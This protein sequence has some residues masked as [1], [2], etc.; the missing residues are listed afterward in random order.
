MVI[1]AAA[2]AAL[3]RPSAVRADIT[4]DFSKSDLKLEVNL[5]TGD[6]YMLAN[7]A[8]AFS[9]YTIADPAGFLLGGSTS[10]DPAK[11]LSVSPTAGG[12]TNIY[13]STGNYVNWFKITETASQIAEGQYNNG[14]TNHSSRDDT[15]NIPSGG[16]I[17]FGDIFNTAVDDQD[18]TFDFAEAGTTPTNGR[19]Y[20]GAEVDYLLAGSS[21]DLFW[22]NT[23]ATSNWSNPN[24]WSANSSTGTDNAGVPT[25]G[26]A[27]F[28][29]NTD[30]QN[31]VIT[32]DES[33]AIL[34]LQIGDTGGGTD[35]LSQ[36]A[37]YNL[38]MQ[39]EQVGAASNGTGIHIQS[40]GNNTFSNSLIVG[41][42]LSSNGTYSLSGTGAVNVATASTGTF[43]GMFVGYGGNGTFAQTGGVATIGLPA[44]PQSL[45]LGYAVPAAGTFL[46]SGSGSLVVNGNAYIG[47]DGTGAFLQSGGAASISGNVILAGTD[48]GS[49]GTGTLAISGGSINV[50]G[51][52]TVYPGGT[53]S[54]TAGILT[55]G[56]ITQSGGIASFTNLNVGTANTVAGGNAASYTLNSGTLN[57]AGANINSGAAFI[58]G[59]GSSPATLNLNGGANNALY[60]FAQGITVSS[61]A[62]LTGGGEITN[63]GF[64]VPVTVA[65]TIAPTAAQNSLQIDGSLT[66]QSSS[67][68][69]IQRVGSTPTF[70]SII[71]SGNLTLAGTLSLYE[72][73]ANEAQTTAGQSFVILYTTG[74][75]LTGGFADVTSGQRLTTTD[76]SASF[77]VTINGGVDG[78][79]V[80]SGFELTSAANSFFWKNSVASGSWSN[81]T[82][83]SAV[84]PTGTD[85]AGAPPISSAAAAV[86][87]ANTDTLTHIV[88]LDQNSQIQ[89]LQIGNTGGGTDTLSQA[90]TFNLSMQTEQVGVGTSSVGIHTQSA[91]TNTYSIN[92]M[93]G[94]GTASVGAYNLSG[95]GNVDVTAAGNGT[96]GMFVG[97]DGTGTFNQTG[98]SSTTTVRNL[99]LGYSNTG[100]GT[101]LLSGGSLTVG[102]A[103]YVGYFGT[104]NFIQS[105]GA[106]TGFSYLC[107][108]SSGPGTYVL[109]NGI[110]SGGEDIGYGGTGTLT[111]TGGTNDAADLFVGM[112][113]TGTYVLSA[114]TLNNQLGYT[115]GLGANG[116]FDQSGGVISITFGTANIGNDGDGTFIQTG[117]IQTIGYAGATEDFYVAENVGDTGDY[118]LSGAGSLSVGGSAYVAG[119]GQQ[120]GGTGTLAISGGA[121]A[122]TGELLVYPSGTLTQT[123]GS[124]A[125]GSLDAHA[126]GSFNF[127]G[128]TL[129]INGGSFLVPSAGTTIGNGTSSATLKLANAFVSNGA[130]TIASNA[131]LTGS[132]TIVTPLSVNAGAT[133]ALGTSSTIANLNT[134]TVSLADSSHLVLD[135]NSST[136][137]NDELISSGAVSLGTS[138]FAQLSLADLGSASL[139]AGT[140]FTLIAA[141]DGITGHFANLSQGSVLTLGSNLYTISYLAAGGDDVTL[142]SIT[143]STLYWENGT[144][145][146]NWSSATPWSA[147]GPTGTD[148][149]GPPT[150]ADTVYIANTDALSHIVTLDQSDTI[151]S[152]QIG[153]TG[154]GTD[155]LSQTAAYNLTMQTE[156][157]GAGTAST[158][159]HIQSAGTNSYA[160]ALIIG[161]GTLSSGT[162]SLSGNGALNIDSTGSG[163]GAGMFVGYNGN[164]TF[165]QSG[166][167]VT[168]GNSTLGNLYVGYNSAGAGTYLLSGG[169]LSAGG[170]EYVGHAGAGTFNQT[171]GY[172]NEGAGTLTVGYAN[173][174]GNYF[175]SSGTLAV[176]GWEVVGEA[177]NGTF[178][179]S[180][181]VN[182]CQGT[183]YLGDTGTGT[184]LM[185]AGTLT[186][187]GI[188][189]GN[190]GSTGTFNQSGGVVNSNGTIALGN[191]SS[192][193]ATYILS[194][195]TFNAYNQLDVG[196]TGALAQSG[197][198]FITWGNNEAVGFAGA[199]TMTQTGGVNLMNVGG[200]LFVGD[201]AGSTGTYLLSGTGS[202]TVTG[203]EYVGNSGNGNLIQSGGAHLAQTVLVANGSMSTGN[204]ALSAG[205]FSDLQDFIGVGGSGTFNQ[206]GG[207]HTTTAL[208]LG[209]TPGSAGT[210]LL[211]GTGSLAVSGTASLGGS[212]AGGSGT[213]AISG[214]SMSITAALNIFAGGYLNQSAGTLSAGSINQ[215]GGYAAFNNLNVGTAAITPAANVGSY[216]LSGGTLSISG[217]IFNTGSAFVVGNGASAATLNLNGGATGALYT[218]AH[219]LNISSASTLT[220]GG[221]ITNPGFNVPVTVAGTIA[222]TAA[223]NSLQ[224]DGS[225]TLQSA[226]TT[227]IQRLGST[228][229]FGAIGSSGNMS[230]AGTLT[231]YEDAA[232]EAQTTAGQSFVILSSTGGLLSGTF[233]DVTSGQRLTT[234]DGSASFIVTINDGVDG[235][236]VLSGFELSTPP[237]TFYWK[238]SIPAGNWSNGGNWS[239]ASPSGTDNAGAPPVTQPNSTTV[240][241]LTNTDALSHI[242]TLDQNTQIQSLLIASSGGG[243]DTLS[244]TTS[245]NITAQNEVVGMGTNGIGQHIQ[246]AATN[247]CTGSLEIGADAGSAGT[248]TLNGAGSVL[249]TGNQTQTAGL[250]VGNNGAGT[251]SQT[252]GTVVVGT[253]LSTNLSIG[254]GGTGTGVYQL[255]GTGSLSVNGNLYVGGSASGAGGI[256]TLAISGGSA[257]I[258]SQVVVYPGGT[259]T[260]TAGNT[261]AGTFDAH[262]AGS[263][264]LAGGTLEINGGN[265]LLPSAGTTIGNGSSKAV[266]ELANNATASNGTIT[267]ANNASLIGDGTITTALYVNSGGTLSL[268]PTG[269]TTLNAAKVSLADGSDFAA[270]INSSAKTSDELISS[271]AVS[272]GSS[273]YSQLAIAD[274]GFSSLPTGTTFTLIAAAGGVSGHFAGLAQGSAITI[275]SNKYNIS[276]LAAG[277][278]D[279]TLSAAGQTQA[280][281]DMKLEV[282]PFTGDVYVLANTAAAFTGYTI[283]DPAHHLL[284]GST[285]PDPDKLLSVAA[286]NGGNTNIYETTGNYVNWFKI[287]ETA[288]QIAEGQYNNGFANHSSRD[289]TIN[290][291]AGGTIDFGDIYNTQTALQDL[292]FDFAEAGTNPTNGPTYYGAEVDYTY[293]STPEP[294]TLGLL[295]MSGILLMR[296][297]RS[298]TRQTKAT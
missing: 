247:T 38:T 220:G 285:S 266:L 196:D 163:T 143:P 31:H 62:T 69:A 25:A 193:G 277:G 252:A 24:N 162:Y 76:G 188:D 238:N 270:D 55:T 113:T 154:G 28:I 294:A 77:I 127:A 67:T 184:Y 290:I 74:G 291:P 200:E 123:A 56:A 179:Q 181:G 242:I 275:G 253:A 256:A 35:T 213:L 29:A 136:L 79:V 292:T 246:S 172:N 151:N 280:K 227:A 282:N 44:S 118:A 109:S 61:A 254:A 60:T 37:A 119:D 13:E 272:L 183:L 258:T 211:S 80:L 175:L 197:G 146:G 64:N 23:A 112:Q 287:T 57:I 236:V 75:V 65:G 250:Y 94:S 243:T 166:G 135:F 117:G 20:Y 92:L 147:V 198:T 18:L 229:S 223:Q 39:T 156:Q 207:L 169:T 97:Y 142:T 49:G 214:G 267:I 297:R 140:T 1:A 264:N 261:S 33:D 182:T 95:T 26:Q 150:A 251:F 177:A 73:A 284:A 210:Y 298:A 225:L 269:Q 43:L 83:W 240:V 17:D 63:P 88:T 114:G 206:S 107:L 155:T 230:L 149:S 145:S 176:G 218:F 232:N 195:G 7:T 93:I 98:L 271:G 259:F 148:A 289:D 8:V 59:N 122:V 78:D 278:D 34:S 217:G 6:V 165:N 178:T 5:G 158:A 215:S 45:F 68:T 234:T 137:K 171:G 231:L 205:T 288:S 128:G 286:V 167:T 295:S 233:A 14:F 110:L 42:T 222:P 174:A 138:S 276:Y 105:G 187:A 116:T 186:V 120:A 58:V 54:Q 134:A 87:I 216:T 15:I 279:V 265:F 86:N 72:D 53:V 208:I 32:L 85:N 228:P 160:S 100:S 84:S 221:E 257:S 237:S 159:I 157:V 82:N 153:S 141:S 235:D 144:P 180:G 104:G 106:N 40:A 36:T 103:E 19:T 30:A 125:V 161:A 224:I 255:S 190:A 226:S 260:Q 115:V 71:T 101:Y 245:A 16:T 192:S 21:T 203:Y 27:V 273:T 81:G 281:T 132:G 121:M 47:F 126:A 10:P 170:Y 91:G 202:L 201:L 185:S 11:L 124:L 239:G 268:G 219:G 173:G 262:A 41:Q 168:V 70:G 293:G 66:L 164:G 96:L 46:L 194:N 90:G 204:I 2:L 189:F 274:L 4:P 102:N 9:G 191:F 199:G 244:Q 3:C 99:Y 131:S 52:M 133:L 296:R 249:I 129:T 50:G 22:K 248:Y 130:L 152:L 209:D 212:N 111:Q 48:S 108:G 12:N 51:M 89:S 283:S 241:A 263:F 139:A